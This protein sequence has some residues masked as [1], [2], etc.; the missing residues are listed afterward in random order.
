MARYRNEWRW[1]LATGE[2]EREA[3]GES[4]DVRGTAR[5]RTARYKDIKHSYSKL[6]PRVGWRVSDVYGI[7][8]GGAAGGG[9]VVAKVEGVEEEEVVGRRKGGGQRGGRGWSRRQRERS[10][11]SEPSYL[12]KK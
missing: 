8:R 1:K 12:Q 3:R 2:R 9:A 6:I 11:G 4:S 10:R 7:Y 5:I